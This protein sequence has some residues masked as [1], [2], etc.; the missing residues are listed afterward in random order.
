MY[1]RGEGTG[2]TNKCGTFLDVMQFCDEND[3]ISNGVG[4]AI[5][6][7]MVYVYGEGAGADCDVGN[8]DPKSIEGNTSATNVT[9]EIASQDKKP[10]FFFGQA[11]CLKL[12][13][14]KTAGTASEP[15]TDSQKENDTILG[16]ATMPS[17]DD[18]NVSTSIPQNEDH[19]QNDTPKL[20][21]ALFDKT[22]E[23]H[24][25]ED[26]SVKIENI[27]SNNNSSAGESALQSEIL[28]NV[29]CPKSD[30]L[31]QKQN[32]QSENT[33]ESEKS[34]QSDANNANEIVVGSV[35]NAN[36]I[37]SKETIATTGSD[38]NTI[39]ESVNSKLTNSDVHSIEMIQHILLPSKSTAEYKSIVE[40]A[41]ELAPNADNPSDR[42]ETKTESL[43]LTHSEVGT[44]KLTKDESISLSRENTPETN[45]DSEERITIAS[46]GSSYS[47]EYLQSSAQADEFVKST[48]VCPN[49][50]ST[51]P[52][53]NNPTMQ[54]KMTDSLNDLNI[55]R[56]DP[57]AIN[58]ET[59]AKNV[60]NEHV[61][62]SEL[63]INEQE[64]SQDDGN[65]IQDIRNIVPHSIKPNE[66]QVKNCPHL[67]ETKTAVVENVSKNVPEELQLPDDTKTQKTISNKDE[68]VSSAKPEHT[69]IEPP[70][71][72]ELQSL[73]EKRKAAEQLP[74]E[75]QE[76]KKVCEESLRANEAN[77]KSMETPSIKP[78]DTT[79]F[80]ETEIE[81]KTHFRKQDNKAKSP[82]SKIQQIATLLEKRKDNE[83]K[84]LS[85][86]KGDLVITA[87]VSSLAS[88]KAQD[89]L[90]VSHENIADE[91]CASVSKSEKCILENNAKAAYVKAEKIQNLDSEKNTS[92][93]G[94]V[95]E[96]TEETSSCLKSDKVHS[97]ENS[98]I[99]HTLRSRKRR[100][101]NEKQRTSSESEI[102]NADPLAHT[103][104]DDDDDDVVGGKRQ[105]MRP[106]VSMR[107]IRKNAEEKR[108]LI[109]TTECST[110]EDNEKPA[111]RS[112]KVA[113]TSTN[114]VSESTARTR[115]RSKACVKNNNTK[116]KT[117]DD[118]NKSA[119]ISE[120]DP[121][122]LENNQKPKEQ[123]QDRD[124]EKLTNVNDKNKLDK[125]EISERKCVTPPIES[126]TTSQLFY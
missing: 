121:L 79:I 105:K 83:M 32:K 18:V 86:N 33:I 117:N 37:R 45:A 74:S 112:H 109:E 46:V 50:Q 36:D 1:V 15:S 40:S 111:T 88:A 116:S 108:N 35:S 65:K 84:T 3:D 26:E 48:E 4:E 21:D 87:T 93:V 16:D 27:Q 17:T 90:L 78:S 64:Y 60:T 6:E 118:T 95:L 30:S 38:N 14:M 72:S 47:Q 77:M 70:K 102:D 41:T 20:N 28:V 103:L 119:S 49:D 44:S 51:R 96:A 34:K 76:Q 97:A 63:M 66:S 114:I 94:K 89:N 110:D 19:H 91:K 62:P 8:V 125:T 61:S 71:S 55:V 126:G 52:P 25:S 92:S 123:A 85:D 23:I 54:S 13:P 80:E 12:S 43:K 100:I 69:S 11:G 59:G 10:M 42:I 81:K 58:D 39:G 56:N 107:N 67:N 98:F 57:V 2:E 73:S 9:D 122:S 31:E 68:I 113:T 82:G 101:S 29:V 104:N 24:K 99:S 115:L 124:T 106:R 22:T 7:D 53:S 5:E 75:S 120:T